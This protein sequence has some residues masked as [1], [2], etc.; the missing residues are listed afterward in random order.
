M[1]LVADYGDSSASD[2]ES[3]SRSDM[4]SSEDFDR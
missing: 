3:T 2:N 1:S 4:D